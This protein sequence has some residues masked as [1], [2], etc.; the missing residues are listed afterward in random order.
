[1][2]AKVIQNLIRYIVS[3]VQDAQFE[4]YRTRLVKLLYLCDVNYFQ[5][6]RGLLTNLKWVRY[7]FG[8]YAF[9][10][11]EITGRMGLALG[12][13]ETDFSSGHGIRYEVYE[14]SNIDTW[15]D[16]HQ[17]QIV[18][19]VIKRWG[20]EDLNVLLD[21]VYCETA[22]M[23]HAQFLKPLDFHNIP[24]GL[25]NSETDSLELDKDQI[26][27]LR[28]SLDTHGTYSESPIIYRASD[29]KGRLGGDEAYFP[30]TLGKAKFSDTS[31]IIPFE[32]RE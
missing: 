26:S 17:K 32:G 22:P 2:T 4:I 25:R 1:M 3:E 9:E 21:Y 14:L 18:D 12:E 27:A 20:G 23:L 11:T 29:S 7:K 10:L 6:R 13:E 5:S 19:N 16:I 24:R 31:R 15:L 28:K 30:I 8:P